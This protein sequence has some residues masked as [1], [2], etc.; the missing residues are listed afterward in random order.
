MRRFVSVKLIVPLL[1]VMLFAACNK[2]C[3]CYRYDG[4]H[5]FFTPEEV[6]ERGGSCQ[7]MIYYANYRPYSICEWDY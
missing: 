2:R 3:H 1:C 4:G 5:D 6:D 7:Q